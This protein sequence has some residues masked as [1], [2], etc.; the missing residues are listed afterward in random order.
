[1]NI[2]QSLFHPLTLPFL[3]LK[4]NQKQMDSENLTTP[5][6][7][8]LRRFERLAAARGRYQT[9]RVWFEECRQGLSNLHPND[10]MSAD[11][12]PQCG[13][14]FS[15]SKST[16]NSPRLI[17]VP[18]QQHFVRDWGRPW[19]FWQLFEGPSR[20]RKPCKQT[21]SGRHWNSRGRRAQITAVY[22]WKVATCL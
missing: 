7:I 22:K 12:I 5:G 18:V 15:V 17:G 10:D 20:V 8:A 11:R 9:F 21:E 3:I 19:K 16:H 1:M 4:V 13:V 6:G 2:L 14:A